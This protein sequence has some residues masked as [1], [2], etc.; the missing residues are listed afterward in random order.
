MPGVCDY[1][2][3]RDPE[4]ILLRLSHRRAELAHW[5]VVARRW[6]A[7]LAAL[8][9]LYNVVVFLGLPQDVEIIVGILTVISGVCLGCWH[10]GLTKGIELRR[11]IE[12]A[13]RDH[14]AAVRRV[15]HE[16]DEALATVE[17][18]VPTSTRLLIPG[19]VGEVL[20]EVISAHA[21]TWH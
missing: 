7:A 20:T 21:F 19:R 5:Q 6:W 3:D 10:N 12:E 11:S 17:P 16:A 18:P 13:E 14:L 2:P 9:A 1:M 8:V 15:E 4:V